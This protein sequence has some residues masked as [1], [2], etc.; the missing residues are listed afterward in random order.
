MA[1]AW[2]LVLAGLT[3]ILSNAQAEAGPDRLSVLLGS[4]HIGATRDFEEFNPGLF[5]IWTNALWGD[6]LDY[7]FGAFRNSYGDG[8]AALLT[9]Y[10]FVRT[11]N[12][13][14]EVFGALAWYPNNGDQFSHAIDD[15]VPVAG[16]QARYRF[17]FM[18]VLPAGGQGVDAT[19]T[20]GL[21]LPLN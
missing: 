7:G 5:L 14:L 16:L 3:A 2:K 11:K 1:K 9:A 20:Y 19:V 4:E 18:Q 15:I 10:P 21:S 8:S 13:G 12:W 17:L 6:R